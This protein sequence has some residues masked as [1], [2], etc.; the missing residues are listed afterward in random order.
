V[1]TESKDGDNSKLKVKDLPSSTLKIE[2]LQTTSPFQWTSASR[3]HP[4]RVRQVNEDACLDQP[5]KGLWAVADGMGGHTLGEFAS[6]LAVESLMDLPA[7]D[8]LEQRVNAARERLQEA[9][10]QLRAEALRRETPLIGTTIAALVAA[11]HRCACLWA[12]DSRIHLYRDGR[13]TQLTRDHSHL[14]A[15]R[16]RY[17]GDSDDTLIRP[18][19][20]LITRAL[21]CEDTLELDEVTIELLDGDMFLLCS[22]G[23]SNEVSELFIEQALLTGICALACDALLD[24]ALEREARDNITAVVVSA[25]DLSSP[26]R[27]LLRAAP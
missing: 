21:G 3:S 22:D 4:G 6:R 14:E 25:E 23:L 13:L 10:R 8:N 2:D 17:I 7:T 11:G 12:G 24:M 27:T 5:E 1:S 18:R 19:A 9:N 26:D 15:A 20:N 16:A